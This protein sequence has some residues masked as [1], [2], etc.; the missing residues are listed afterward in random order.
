MISLANSDINFYDYL[1][2]GEGVSEIHQSLQEFL[3]LK[4][5]ATLINKNFEGKAGMC[6][7]VKVLGKKYFF[8][9]NIFACCK[10][11]NEKEDFISTLT[12]W[13]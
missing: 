6:N 10:F 2:P 5:D 9:V 4:V 13:M 12:E 7:S 3:D 11:M 8:S 1:F